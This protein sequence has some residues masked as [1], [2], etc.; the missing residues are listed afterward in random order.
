MSN[1]CPNQ[2]CL[3]FNLVQPNSSSILRMLFLTTFNTSSVSN[4][5]PNQVRHAFLKFNY[6]RLSMTNMAML[7]KMTDE[8]SD[9]SLHLDESWLIWRIALQH[10]S[11]HQ[12]YEC[13]IHKAKQA[14]FRWQSL[15]YSS[16]R[17]PDSKVHGANTHLGPV[18]P[19]WVPRWPHEPCYGGWLSAVTMLSFLRLLIHESDIMQL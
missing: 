9:T 13:C 18:G 16:W 17:I 6:W 10:I 14:I 2:C 5:Y 1:H 15:S 19:S 7:F 12:R 11:D 3:N 4:H 8:I